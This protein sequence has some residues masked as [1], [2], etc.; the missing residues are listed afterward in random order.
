LARA[1]Q[2]GKLDK[3][4]SGS[5][6]VTLSAVEANN[7]V[8]NL[9]GALT[10]NINVILPVGANSRLWAVTNNTIGAY[11]VTMKGA[12]GAGAVVAQGSKALFGQDGTNVFA[13][14]LSQQAIND[15]VTAHEAEPDPH[16]QYLT[17][18][19]ADSRYTSST[20]ATGVSSVNGHAGV[21]TLGASDVG[22]VASSALGAANGAASLDSGGKLPASQL[23]D[24]AIIDFLGTVANQTAMLALSGQKGDWCA[25]S[26]N[27]KVYVITGSD[28]TQVGSW[29]A[30]SY[31]TGTGGT[32]TSVALTT[33]GLLFNVSG[34]PVTGAGTLA[35]SLKTQTA[36]T[37]LAGPT[38]GA[39]ATP[40]MRALTAAD[41]P[42][43]VASGAGHAG[44]AV[45]DP[46]STAGTTRYLRE[47][48][49]WQAPSG[50]GTP[51]GSTTQLQFNDAGGLG[52]ASALNWDKANNILYVGA[53]ATAGNIQGGAPAA[54]I[55]TGVSVTVK[56]GTGGV[57]NGTGGAVNITGGTG[58]GGS[59]AG[60]DVVITGGQ[61]VGAVTSS[62]VRINGG[63]APATAGSRGGGV[64]ITAANGTST[65]T[66][67]GGGDVT[68]TAGNTVGT[69]GATA[70]GVS[71]S[72]GSGNS[73]GTSLGG[74]VTISSGNGG[75][76]VNAGAVNIT[77]GSGGTTNGIGGAINITAGSSG[78]S[79]DGGV[80]TI[81]G[82]TGGTT[83]GNGGA[84][85]VTAGSPAA[86]NGGAVNITAS[87]GVGTNKNGGNVNLTPGAATGTGTPGNVVLNNSGAALATTA[88]GGFTCIP[89]C[90]GAPTGTPANIPT[91]TV[92]MVFD[93]TN[94]K[95]WIYTGGAWK[96][97]V[98]S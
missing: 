57:T 83:T 15:A 68:I 31:P 4:I 5:T 76:N 19:E 88:I 39:D 75:A 29:T 63:P 61:G 23:P 48:G 42:V 82:G 54:D 91:G 30:L 93:T 28:P 66:G 3:D 44:G 97:A 12:L 27:S 50:S 43:M 24:L 79:K 38:T 62:S 59:A 60:G 20:A 13:L 77:G 86:G 18:T 47:D 34:S 71:I 70:G 2:I 41:L 8:I 96:G 53:G 89:T 56:G 51:G 32:V 84:V 7:T 67:S 81:K 74:S 11:T 35:F 17:Q 90:A 40:T 25:R 14:G 46:G 58:G 36:N 85:N 10:A 87:A 1:W 22:A 72:A 78:T 37:F 21:V 9:T 49:T 6:D 52:G 95:F 98:L 92:P 26:D 33:P 45:P 80:V 65:G 16:P 73:S 55:S 69:V 64:L 94:S